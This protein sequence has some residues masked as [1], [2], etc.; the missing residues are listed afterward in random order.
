MNVGGRALILGMLTLGMR[1]A[2]EGS[3]PK[4]AGARGRS[5]P[6]P[7]LRD[8]IAAADS[9]LFTAFNDR[10]L[11]KLMSFF[12]RDVEFYQ[13]N[14]GA[15]NYA[16]TRKDFAQMFAQPATIRRELVTGSL[17]VF[18]IEK[19]GAIEVGRHR[20]C[21]VE[22]GKEECGTFNFVHIWRRAGKR[23]QISRVVSC[24]H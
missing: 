19:Y 4:T 1:A 9:A 11:T 22:G 5:S 15:E 13:D 21:H 7:T 8:T 2:T 17:E 12:A 10:S 23:W 16:Q 3:T 14:E 6:P 20:F 18:P 24:G